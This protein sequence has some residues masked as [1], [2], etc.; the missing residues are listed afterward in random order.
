MALMDWWDK[1]LDPI[2]GKGGDKQAGKAEGFYEEAYQD[3]RDVQAPTLDEIDPFLFEY[4]G[5]VNPAQLDSWENLIANQGRASNVDG[6]AFDNI[7]TDP[8]LRDSQ[9]DALSELSG[10]ANSGGL[11]LSDKAQLNRIFNRVDQNDRA[12]REAI[13]MRQNARGMGGS[14][15]DL[16]AQLNSAQAGTDDA[17]QR[18]M[19]LAALAQDRSLQ[20]IMSGADMAGTIRQQ[21]YGEAADA[22]KAR[23]MLN[24]FNSRMSQE[25]SFRNAGIRNDMDRYNANRRFDT[26]RYNA[27]AM[28]DARFKNRNARQGTLDDNTDVRNRALMYNQ[29]DRLRN[30]FGMDHRAAT[31]RQG[32]AEGMGKYWTGEAI[33]KDRQRANNVNTLFGAGGAGWDAFGKVAGM[34]GGAGGGIGG[35]SGAGGGSQGPGAEDNWWDEEAHG[36]DVAT[37]YD[38]DVGGGNAPDDY[39][40]KEPRRPIAN[41]W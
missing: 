22:A 13:M 1:L 16:M 39:D 37:D 24:Q 23:D 4:A 33:R 7:S 41:P 36:G 27:N 21:D 18:G 17:N 6:T 25:A 2:V 10:I 11:R 14:G 12:R 8:R 34:F 20:A 28:T 31:M 35:G 9:L 15:M 40:P 5:D 19:D 29:G 26:N 3:G 38:Q 32:A 30:Q